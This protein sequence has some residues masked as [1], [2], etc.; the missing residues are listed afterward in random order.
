MKRLIIKLITN[1]TGVSM[2]NFILFLGGI[3]TFLSVIG[4]IVLLYFDFFYPQYTLSI[5][6]LTY[7]GVITSIEG[8][9]ALLFFLKVKSEKQEIPKGYYDDVV[10]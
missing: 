7:A 1:N 4:F 2:K 6:L 10:V 9:L 8:M 5:N 3:L